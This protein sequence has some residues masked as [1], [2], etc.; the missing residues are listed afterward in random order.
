MRN[1]FNTRWKLDKPLGIDLIVT[2]TCPIKATNLA[3]DITRTNEIVFKNPKTGKVTV[4]VTNI[5]V[6][7]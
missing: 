4:V 6:L 1:Q 5:K 7:G 2:V 3:L